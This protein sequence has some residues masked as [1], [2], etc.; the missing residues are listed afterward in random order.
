MRLFTAARALRT[1]PLPLPATACRS[2]SASQHLLHLTC[3]FRDLP[4]AEGFLKVRTLPGGGERATY[5]RKAG[6]GKI[7]FCS[8]TKQGFSYS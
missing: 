1:P 7:P 8:K 5:P 4:K 6:G 3:I 2:A